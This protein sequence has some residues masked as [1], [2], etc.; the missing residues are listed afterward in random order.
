M[1]K[2]KTAVQ[3]AH[4]SVTAFMEARKTV[5]QIADLWFKKGQKKVAVRVNSLDELI[6]LMNKAKS[7]NLPYALISDMGLTELEPGTVTALGIG[8]E[9]SEKIDLITGHLKLL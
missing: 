9:R 2:G 4:A 6:E 1:S 8:P 7:M 5:P 3:A